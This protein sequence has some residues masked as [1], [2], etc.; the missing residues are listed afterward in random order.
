M[1]HGIQEMLLIVVH[2]SPLQL[3]RII[4]LVV[5]VSED[6]SVIDCLCIPHLLVL[7]TTIKKQFFFNFSF[8]EILSSHE[9]ELVNDILLF[10]NIILPHKF[11]HIFTVL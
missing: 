1:L 9:P 3:E 4:I 5:N 10:Q 2:S 8:G 6:L 11:T 7:W